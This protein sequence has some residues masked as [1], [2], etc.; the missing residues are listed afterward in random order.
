[1]SAISMRPTRPAHPITP[2]LVSAMSA[3]L[4]PLRSQRD[5][6]VAALLAMTIL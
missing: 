1:M 6:F 4:N 2:I 5:C 3:S